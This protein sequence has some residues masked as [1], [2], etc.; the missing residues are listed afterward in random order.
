MKVHVTKVTIADK[1]KQGNPLINPKSNK[2][3]WRVGMQTQE[4]KDQ[5]LSGFANSQKDVDYWKGMEGKEVDIEIEEKVSGDR[6]FLNFRLPKFDAKEGI[7]QILT[8]MDALTAYL[9]REFAEFRQL[10]SERTHIAD[11]PDASITGSDAGIR[12]DLKNP[13]PHQSQA[14][15]GLKDEVQSNED[16]K[17]G[18]DGQEANEDDIGSLKGKIF[19]KLKAIAPQPSE[20]AQMLYEISEILGEDGRLK[21]KAVRSVSDIKDLGHAQAIYKV[22][23]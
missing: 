10:L 7:E 18:E 17:K 20:T 5:W 11:S 4:H 14:S 15:E 12:E 6:T 13:L 19:A 1:D 16:R 3:Y 22:L 23:K 21:Y 9:E 8:K 2:P